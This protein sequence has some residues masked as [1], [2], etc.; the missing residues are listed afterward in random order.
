M[1]ELE[2]YGFII[3]RVSYTVAT[4]T[5]TTKHAYSICYNVIPVPLPDPRSELPWA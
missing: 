3:L 5:A 4:V 1:L 2:P